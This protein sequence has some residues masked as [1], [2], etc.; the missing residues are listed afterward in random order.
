M[1]AIVLVALLCSMASAW[2]DRGHLLT[3]RV[4]QIILEKED[5]DTY[6]QSVNILK[7]LKETD[8]QWTESE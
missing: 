3:A 4:A 2:W 6:Q 1:K 5:P 8:P 7:K